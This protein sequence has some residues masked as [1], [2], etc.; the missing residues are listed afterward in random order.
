[1]F[2]VFILDVTRGGCESARDSERQHQLPLVDTIRKEKENRNI[3]LWLV[4]CCRRAGL[5]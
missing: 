1:M 2:Y 3:W 5:A 4:C